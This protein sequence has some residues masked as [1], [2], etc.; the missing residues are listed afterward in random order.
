[1]AAGFSFNDLAE[2]DPVSFE[3]AMPIPEKG[4]RARNVRAAVPAGG[5]S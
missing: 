5:L 2:D 1:M 4:P 3:P